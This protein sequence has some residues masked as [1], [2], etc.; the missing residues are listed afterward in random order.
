MKRFL[1]IIIAIFIGIQFVRP[2]KNVSDNAPGPDHLTVLYPPSSEVKAIFEKACYDCHSNNTRYPWY[3][4]VQPVAWWLNDHIQ[5]GKEHFN[6]E[7][8]G[9]YST[10]RQLHKLEELIEEV[11]EDEMPLPS[12]QLAHGD[13]RL[14]E[15][16]VNTLIAWTASVRKQIKR[17]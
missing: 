16:E 13:A 15:D 1:I 2:E 5:E 9:T 8:F 14:T 6:F 11:E 17:Q 12:Y 7:E 3:A 4:N 10:K